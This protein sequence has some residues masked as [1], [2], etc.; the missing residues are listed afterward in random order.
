M[1]NFWLDRKG[2]KKTRVNIWLSASVAADAFD[3]EEGATEKLVDFCDIETAV[4]Q[5]SA[6]TH[7]FI[8]EGTNEMLCLLRVGKAIGPN[9]L[10]GDF[11]KHLDAY[12]RTATQWWKKAD[13]EA[14][15]KEANK[16]ISEAEAAKAKESAFTDPAT[17]PV[18]KPVKV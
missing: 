9:G 2:P 10:G 15:M 5:S 8:P 16:Q 14:S 13:W 4:L 11:S 18:A 7:K 1:K 17:K 6:V 3:M 12:H